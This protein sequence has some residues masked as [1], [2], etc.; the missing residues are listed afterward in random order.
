MKTIES[1]RAAYNATKIWLAIFGILFFFFS[2]KQGQKGTSQS[3]RPIQHF[4]RAIQGKSSGG[5]TI[6]TKIPRGD[7]LPSPCTHASE[8]G[9]VRVRNFLNVMPNESSEKQLE[10]GTGGIALSEIR[11]VDDTKE[12]QNIVDFINSDP[13]YQHPQE[14]VD[15]TRYHYQT[16]EF[17][18]VFWIS[19]GM[20][21]RTVSDKF[22]VIKKDF[23]EAWIY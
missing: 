12:C 2:C 15:R 5:T 3:E 7:K 19:N 1:D 18:Y 6:S 11:P 22:I 9:V 20:K 4:D 14:N 17:Y 16:N 23:S 10:S 8:F 21:L 13:R